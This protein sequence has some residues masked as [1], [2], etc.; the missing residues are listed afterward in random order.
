M[1]SYINLLSPFGYIQVKAL[2][3][4][5]AWCLEEAKSAFD[6]KDAKEG[7]L[8]R[9]VGGLLFLRMGTVVPDR[10]LLPLAIRPH[11][12]RKCHEVILQG[13]R[14]H[15]TLVETLDMISTLFYFK[16]A[17]DVARSLLRNCHRCATHH[18]PNSDV[19]ES[20]S[21]PNTAARPLVRG[22]TCPPRHPNPPR[23]EANEIHAAPP[24]TSS[25][26]KSRG[27]KRGRDKHHRAS[28]CSHHLPQQVQAQANPNQEPNGG[29]RIAGQTPLGNPRHGIV[30]HTR[31]CGAIT[32][33][34][35]GNVEIKIPA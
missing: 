28:V 25:P 32:I 11:V 12:I 3:D 16:G 27:R 31:D 1:T 35:P 10:M 7:E 34:L 21:N 6:E 24:F 4:D 20:Y 9:G 8:Y 23:N 19:S 22:G 5:D 29:Q 15:H 33:S 2:Q 18:V 14:E 17:H 13:H 30:A 26:P